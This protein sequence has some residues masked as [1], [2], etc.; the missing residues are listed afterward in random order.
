MKINQVEEL[1][2]VTKKNI[3][4]YE[5][6]GLLRPE[7]NPANGYREYTLKDVERLKTIKL[8]RR[9]DVPCGEIRAVLEGECTLS[10]C[11]DRHTAAL[12]KRALDMSHILQ[13]CEKL[14]AEALTLEDLNPDEY[15]ETM[16]TLEKGGVTFMDVEKSDV[17]KRRGGA[18]LSAAVWIVL[19]AGLILAALW[20]NKADPLPTGVL[21]AILAVPAAVI[22]GVV[23]A[24]VQ[25]M[26]ELKGGEYDEARKY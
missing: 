14:K 2:G 26:K 7:R 24:L 13:L 12:E 17:G 19:M 10:D 1:V 18:I 16:K 5:D 9:L 4:F 25:R 15:L 22:I 6:E 3:R 8:L 20:G 23:I 11:L 21:I